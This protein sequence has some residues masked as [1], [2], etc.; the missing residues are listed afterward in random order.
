MKFIESKL[1]GAFIIEL[2][3]LTD[4]RGFF[5]RSW[6]EK[7]FTAQ[8]LTE[9]MVQANVGFSER[10]GTVRGIHFQKSPHAEAKLV[11]CTRGSL[12]D[13]VVDLRSDSPTC[14]QWIGVELTADN[15]RM[16]YVPEGFGHACQ[17]LVDATEFTYQT[18]QFYYPDSAA[19]YRY[20]DPAFRIRW[21][22][23][24][25]C[26]SRADQTWPDFV[27]SKDAD[28]SPAGGAL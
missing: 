25:S 28:A 23:E 18:S 17:T 21:P 9:R 15:A 27:V 8:G 13:V 7:E 20:D 24:V 6:C 11:R 14:G 2:D 12:Y 5:A 1:P 26:V 10:A 4:D 19:G 3:R 16:V 22:L